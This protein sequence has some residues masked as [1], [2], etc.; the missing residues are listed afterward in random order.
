MDEKETEICYYEAIVGL[1]ALLIH[2]R[3]L[4]TLKFNF[5]PTNRKLEEK[6]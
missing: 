6:I 1:R 2:V 5:F 3:T 4:N